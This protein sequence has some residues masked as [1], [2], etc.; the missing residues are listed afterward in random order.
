M[1]YNLAILHENTVKI[2][3]EVKIQKT[4]AGFRIFSRGGGG[5]VVFPKSFA[6]QRMPKIARSPFKISIY[7]P[8]AEIHI[9]QGSNP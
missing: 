7:W 6:F 4:R 5:R 8:K 1:V 2:S 9:R 3:K